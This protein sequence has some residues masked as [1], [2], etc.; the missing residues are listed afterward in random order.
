MGRLGHR[1]AHAPGPW[2]GRASPGKTFPTALDRSPKSVL[3]QVVGEGADVKSWLDPFDNK[4][5][6]TGIGAVG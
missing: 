2:L 3:D 5:A 6:L 4:G 1:R